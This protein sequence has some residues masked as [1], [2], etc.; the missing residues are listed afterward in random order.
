[1][2]SSGVFTGAWTLLPFIEQRFPPSTAQRAGA[3][4]PEGSI[5]GGRAIPVPPCLNGVI[6]FPITLFSL[7]SDSPALFHPIGTWRLLHSDYFTRGFGANSSWVVSVTNRD[8][9]KGPQ[10]GTRLLSL[11]RSHRGSPER[12]N[13]AKISLKYPPWSHSSSLP[14]WAHKCCWNKRWLNTFKIH[15]KGSWH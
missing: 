4:L 2:G 14:A 15:F 9:R 5:P 10:G 3:L 8:K 7:C 1:M 13:S 6:I 12:L 11:P